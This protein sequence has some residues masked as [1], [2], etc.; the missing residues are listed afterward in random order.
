MVMGHYIL[1]GKNPIE[2]DLMTWGKWFETADRHVAK[3]ED[4]D[5]FIS[6]VFLG[7]DHSF[8]DGP[9]VLFETMVFGGELDE[10]MNRYTTWED[11]E[12][13]HEEMV[14]RVMGSLSV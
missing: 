5:I 3:F 13:G 9:P 12:K 2:S 14:K 10:E 8:G 7:I 11:A 1:E 6:T 4:K